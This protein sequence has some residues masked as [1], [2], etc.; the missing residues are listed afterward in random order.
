MS[1]V[2][3]ETFSLWT[4]VAIW[5]LILGPPAVFLWFLGEVR[6]WFQNPNSGGIRVRRRV[7]LH[8]PG[9]EGGN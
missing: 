1:P 5:I 4:W 9:T 3:L 6:S 8:A 7:R 2:D